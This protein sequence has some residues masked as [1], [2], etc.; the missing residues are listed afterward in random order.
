M[1]AKRMDQLFVCVHTHIHISSTGLFC[2][3]TWLFCV[4]TCFFCA[5]N[6]SAMQVVRCCGPLRIP[7]ASR[8]PIYTQKS[9]GYMQKSPV[10]TQKSPG[11]MRKSPI[12]TQKSPGY[13]RKSFMYTVKSPVLWPSIPSM[14]P[15]M[16]TIGFAR[17]AHRALLCIHRTLLHVPRALLC[18][19]RTLWR[20]HG[21]FVRV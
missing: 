17:S 7:F 6:W 18:I 2:V 5:S 14:R 13:M 9:A 8:R 12:Y 16:S 10:Y 19:H 3:D 20:M 4:Y 21:A 11:Y 15:S 1:C